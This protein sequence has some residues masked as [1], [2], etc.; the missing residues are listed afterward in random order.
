[1]RRLSVFTMMLVA[2]VMLLTSCEESGPTTL[3]AKK[4][5]IDGAL[6][7]NIFVVE[8]ACPF[9]IAMPETEEGSTHVTLTVDFSLVNP[10]TNSTCDPR[11]ELLSG[12]T[13]IATLMFGKDAGDVDIK[14]NFGTY[15]VGH[16]TR[17]FEAT[18]YYN[19][20]DPAE[21]ENIKKVNSFRVVN[22]FK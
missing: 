6:N 5:T 11:V 8:K 19:T 17:V 14:K 12:N 20:D 2:M 15:I 1:M 9:E 4:V 21:V 10:I 22:M 7:E 13:V 18:F 16:S 3:K